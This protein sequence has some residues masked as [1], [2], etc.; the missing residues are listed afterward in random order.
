MRR[1]RSVARLEAVAAR[2]GDSPLRTHSFNLS[3][4]LAFSLQAMSASARLTVNAPFPNESASSP[5]LGGAVGPIRRAIQQLLSGITRAAVHRHH[6]D[7]DRPHT[8]LPRQQHVC[9]GA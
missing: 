8:T 1:R 6:G 4:A 5:P 7:G 9:T 2:R 3:A